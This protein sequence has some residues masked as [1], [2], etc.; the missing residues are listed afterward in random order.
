[1]KTTLNSRD[2]VHIIEHS[3]YNHNYYRNICTGQI[4]FEQSD[5]DHGHDYWWATEEDMT[6]HSHAHDEYIGTCYMEDFDIPNQYSREHE[7]ADE[8]EFE[9]DSEWT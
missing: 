5:D 4:L 6:N 1:M 3:S 9:F 8:Y 2:F 7:C